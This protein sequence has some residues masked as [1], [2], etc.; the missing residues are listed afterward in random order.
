MP[1]IERNC[2]RVSFPYAFYGLINSEYRKMAKGT[3]RQSSVQFVS[4]HHNRRLFIFKTSF[5]ERQE[6]WVRD[7]RTILLIFLLFF[8]RSCEAHRTL[9]GLRTF[10]HWTDYNWV[11]SSKVT[12]WF[13]SAGAKTYVNDGLPWMLVWATSITRSSKERIQS[14]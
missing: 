8:P 1:Y 11:R 5:M 9:R 4:V 12:D 6:P 7:I 14:Q 2:D 10:P 3:M 13:R